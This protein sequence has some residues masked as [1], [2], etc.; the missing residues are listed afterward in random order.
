MGARQSNPADSSAVC[1]L[2]G[3]RASVV[4]GDKKYL[5]ITARIEPR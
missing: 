5:Q 2:F 3:A 1:K 4:V